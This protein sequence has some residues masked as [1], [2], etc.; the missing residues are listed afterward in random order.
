MEIIQ[1]TEQEMFTIITDSN[2]SLV[3]SHNELKAYI[4]KQEKICDKK[5][6]E[7]ER[8]ENAIAMARASLLY[9]GGTE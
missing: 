3:I 6:K 1:D 8:I 7:V 9:T 2:N 5:K 4:D